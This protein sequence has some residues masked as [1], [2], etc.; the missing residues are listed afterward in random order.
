MGTSELYIVKRDGKRE[1]FSVGAI[2]SVSV[3]PAIP[4]SYLA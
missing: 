2:V 3:M 4:F 1:V